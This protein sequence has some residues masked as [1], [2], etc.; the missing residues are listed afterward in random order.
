MLGSIFLIF[1]CVWK[2]HVVLYNQKKQIF[3]L[4]CYCKK[5]AVALQNDSIYFPLSAFYVF[6]AFPVFYFPILTLSSEKFKIQLPLFLCC[7]IVRFACAAGLL[8]IGNC[9]PSGPC[10]ILMSEKSNFC[11][12]LPR[13]WYAVWN[14][15][16]RFWFLFK[17]LY[18]LFS[19]LFLHSHLL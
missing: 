14:Y 12:F 2:T 8:R 7:A 6:P 10:P 16:L 15:L 9:S 3:V 5:N 4:E 18:H 1:F 11:Q 17:L 13:I 19:K